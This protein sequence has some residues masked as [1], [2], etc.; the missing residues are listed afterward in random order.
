MKENLLAVILSSLTFLSSIAYFRY[1]RGIRISFEKTVKQSFFL[2]LISFL[3][4]GIILCF[5]IILL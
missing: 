5:A 3:C 1:Y 2:I 4:G